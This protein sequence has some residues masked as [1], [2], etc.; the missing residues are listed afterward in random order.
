MTIGGKVAQP[1]DGSAR[2]RKNGR[3]R[4][5]PYRAEELVR[6]TQGRNNALGV[7]AL[8]AR[9]TGESLERVVHGSKGSGEAESGDIPEI[10]QNKALVK[11]ANGQTLRKDGSFGDRPLK[12]G[13]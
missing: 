3:R 7:L 5:R 12:L 9:A 10:R 4:N 8:V 6:G 2:R 11:V 1:V 13:V